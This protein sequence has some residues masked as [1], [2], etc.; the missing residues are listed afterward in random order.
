MISVPRVRNS[1]TNLTLHSSII[2][3]LDLILWEQ[4]TCKFNP[5]NSNLE[6]RTFFPV[7]KSKNL[8]FLL[9]RFQFAL[10]ERSGLARPPWRSERNWIFS[11]EL[12][13]SF[14][15]CNIHLQNNPCA[16]SEEAYFWIIYQD[17]RKVLKSRGI[18]CGGHNLF[19]TRFPG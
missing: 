16:P 12:A 6:W 19:P 11:S 8:M 2:H 7:I 17:R 18:V 5:P 15:Y 9:I 10:L 13:R 1:T 14:I 3:L 4:S